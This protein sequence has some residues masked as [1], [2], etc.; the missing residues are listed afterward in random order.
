M[1]GTSQATAFAS[2]AAALLYAQSSDLRRPEQ[3]IDQLVNSGIH[4]LALNGKTKA[5]TV[6]NSYR[7]LAMQDRGTAVTG[8]TAANSAGIDL[9]LFT[10]DH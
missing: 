2:G 6:L 4:T 9:K 3:I 10:Q 7:A 8:V 1:T 5:R